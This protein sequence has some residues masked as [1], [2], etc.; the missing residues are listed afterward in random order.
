MN[1]IIGITKKMKVIIILCVLFFIGIVS[2]LFLMYGPIPTFREWLIT[3]AMTTMNHQYLATWFYS[4]ETIAEVMDKHKVIEVSE[5]TNLDLIS[6]EPIVVEL[7]EEKPT[8]ANEYERQ[9]LE[10]PTH[11]DYKIIPIEGD[12]YSGYLAVIYDPSRVRAVATKN[13]GKSGQY[14]TKMAEEN[15]AIVA[16]N[17][18]GFDDP[19]H[20]SSG[21]TPLGTT[22]VEGKVLT[23]YNYLNSTGGIIGFT[24][25]NKLFLGKMST[26]EAVDMGIRD[27]VSHGPFLIVNRK[28]FVY[29]R[30]WRM[31]KCP[32]NSNRPKTRWNCTIFSIRSEEQYQNLVQI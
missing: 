12:T 32:K 8:Y 22:I 26:Q 20:N 2:F 18:G 13:L 7:E 10:N 5:N 23:D 21:G 24:E 9:V 11:A 28:I 16:I 25:D 4:D 6:N 15:N 30:K 1:A 31:G 3:T 19:N 29:K 27:A 17:G 14:L